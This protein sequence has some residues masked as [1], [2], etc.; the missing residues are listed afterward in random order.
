MVSVVAAGS[1]QEMVASEALIGVKEEPLV[2]LD[3]AEYL[4]GGFSGCRSGGEEEE[5][6]DAAEE[7]LPKPLEGLR[8]IGPPPFLKKTFE[9]V[10]DP[11]TDSIL[12]W[13]G[14]GNSFV[15]WDPHTFATDLL[16][17][18]FK[19]NNFSS[20]V[21]QLNTYRFRK[22]D[23]DRWEFANEGFRRNKKHLL[24]HIKR[25]KQSPQMMRPHEAA[26][27]AQPWQYPTNHGVDS[28]IYKL[29]ADQSLL[30]QEIVK[31]RQQQEC[32][33][34]YIAAMEERL[35]ASEMQQKHMIVF[36]I[37]SL[38]DPMF[39]L[40]CV[41]RINRKRALSSEEVAFKRRRLSEN[42]ES[43][44]G[45]DQDRRFQAQE[46]LSTIP[47]EIQTLFSPDS[48]GSPVQDHKAET[49]LH[50]SDVC[51]DNFI[52][53]EKLMEDDMI[54]DEEQG[55]EKQPSDTRRIG[56]FDPKTVAMGFAY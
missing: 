19:H 53:W 23:S 33:Q 26:A 32:S 42:M 20:F 48:S 49:E 5:W 45:I 13:S 44:I 50:S 15:V 35:H 4:G 3:E 10:D 27:A 25:R 18:H 55:P 41:D 34:R 31:L 28:E 30:R 54:Y 8:D 6:G 9:M 36:M 29:G 52:L 12:S 22:I 38:K 7:H 24:K 40:D 21:R 37:K 17:K 2:F 46:E 11:R 47:S 1:K 43:N 39:L 16:P 51:S 56:E 14:A